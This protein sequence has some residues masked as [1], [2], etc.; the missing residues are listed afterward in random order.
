MS[1]ARSSQS[2]AAMEEEPRKKGSRGG[3]RSVT[4][5]S[6]AQLARKRAND[7]E[8][9]R[10]IRQRTKEHIENLEKKVK[11]LEETNRSG[12]MERVLKRN[13][14]L[15]V[16]V[17]ALRAQIA[18][19]ANPVASD[20]IPSEMPEELLMQQKVSLEW[21]PEPQA[22]A[23]W[24]VTVSSHLQS[25][26][27]PE[28]P[29][30]SGAYNSQPTHV[31]PAATAP[32]RYES[33]DAD[34]KNI[35]TP[36]A[37]PVWEDPMA[38]GNTSQAVS[39]PTPTWA[40][41]H[42]AFNQPSRFADL[43]QSGFT[44][45]LNQPTYANTTCWQQQPSIYAW[46]IS[47][48]LK[49]PVTLVDQLMFGVIH[50]QRQLA[51]HGDVTGEDVIGPS[52]PSVHLLFN[53]PGPAKPPSTLT[54]VMARYSAVLSNRG[55]ALI[56]EKLASFMCMYRFV[57]WQ[58]SPTYQTYQKLHDWQAPRPCQLLTPHPAWMDLPPW[59]KFRE[60]V[61]ENQARYDNPEFQSDY[62]T[63]LCVNFSHDPMKALIFED[64][65]IMVSPLMD[66]HL[67]DISNM[68]MKKPFA[69]KY[70]EFRDVCRFEEL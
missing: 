65:Q 58:I 14:E 70:P 18:A 59:G 25:M 67:S 50:S 13:K 61:I 43:Q 9:Q 27:S 1:S 5:L 42:T 56:P 63:N 11:E 47:T 52:F 3:K 39:Q 38:F 66:Q 22:S 10:N 6:K 8:A 15:E 21:I 40:P 31:Y 68:S 17:E 33:E 7:R 36:T 57:Q 23:Q 48:K 30:S 55:F 34:S 28:I 64:G 19:H 26:D 45:L 2:P 24:P 16:E 54:E 32:M 49:A 60:K 20:S 4:H 37:T 12:S 53:Q 46:Q 69:D 51:L 62:A 44:D 41:F 29:V 35:F